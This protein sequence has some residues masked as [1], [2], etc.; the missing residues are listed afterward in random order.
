VWRQSRVLQI[1]RRGR[2]FA[3]IGRESVVNVIASKRFDRQETM[4]R[5]ISLVLALCGLLALVPSVQAESTAAKP[6][7][8][9]HFLNNDLLGDGKDRWQT[10]SY[11]MSWLRGPGWNGTLPGRPFEILEYRLSGA[12]I[13]PSRLKSLHGDRRY[14]G[15]ASYAIHTPFAP[16]ATTEADLGLGLVWTGPANGISELQGDL[17]DWLNQPSPRAADSQLPN[18]LYPVIS[19][20]IARPVALGRAE[21]RPFAE[22][23]AGDESLLRV[24]ADLAFGKRETGALWLRDEVTGQRYVGI[25][26]TGGEGTSF[27]VGADLTHVFDSAYLPGGW[28]VQ[29]EPN[30]ARLRAGLSTRLGRV[31]VFYGVTW[32]SREFIGQPEGQCVGSLRLRMKF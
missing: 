13:A 4:P 32:L 18:H 1:P 16:T 28:D 11:T 12:V 20:E 14:V 3:G 7:G 22:A 21:V 10:G 19:G 24:G 26:G 25:S 17:H 2:I 6:L 29:P 23:R 9:G 15:K 8:F 30:R 5:L 27:V 31:G